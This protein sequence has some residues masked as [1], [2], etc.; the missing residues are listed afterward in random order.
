MRGEAAG[1]DASGPAGAAARAMRLSP[2]LVAWLIAGYAFLYLPIAFLV[3]FSFNDSR[4]VTVWT[5]FST[6]WYGTL[7]RNGPLIEAALLSLRIAA[8]SATLATAIGT[9]SGYALA[10]FGRFRTCTL[11]EGALA[12]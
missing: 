6:R 5:G 11:F 2:A 10:R 1:A 3:L 12:A 9:A 4:L 7:L 8:V